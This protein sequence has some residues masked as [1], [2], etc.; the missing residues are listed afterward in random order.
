MLLNFKTEVPEVL[1][2][3]KIKMEA[4]LAQYF[5]KD[6]TLALFNGTSNYNLE[7]TKLALT[8]KV[9]IRKIEYPVGKPN[10]PSENKHLLENVNIFFLKT[11]IS[12]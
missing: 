7:K 5:H 11:T 4:V 9:V 3:T 8:E 1:V 6:G 12:L 2:L 10:I